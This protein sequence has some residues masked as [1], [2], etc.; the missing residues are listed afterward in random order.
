[1]AGV[2]S[3]EVDEAGVEIEID[4]VVQLSIESDLV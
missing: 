3:A 2:D 4:Y 1:M